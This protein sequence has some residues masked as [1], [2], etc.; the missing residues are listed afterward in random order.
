VGTVTDLADYYRLKPAVARVRVAELVEDGA[1]VAANVEGW[2]EPGY[3][4]PGTRARRPTRRHATL[5]SPF[6]SLI[7]ERARTQRLFGFDYRIEVYVPGPKRV[8]GYYV[9]PMLLG[10]AL[11]GR[12]DLK[13]DRRTSTLRVAGAFAEPGFDLDAVAVGAADELD[14][15]RRWLGLDSV[16]VASK[17]DLVPALAAALHSRVQETALDPR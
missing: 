3:L 1:L 15:L 14:S 13:A 17:G 9:F 4:L 16:A 6:D 2:R 7:W 11:V 10:D 12:L 5:L 8:H